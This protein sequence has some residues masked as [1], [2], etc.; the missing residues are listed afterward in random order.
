MQA[1]EST[2]VSVTVVADDGTERELKNEGIWGQS[3]TISEMVKDTDPDDKI[4]LHAVTRDAL[5][6][7]VE[8]MENMASLETDGASETDKRAWLDEY[9]K[10]LEPKDQ[11]RVLFETITAASFMNVKGLLDELC[12]FVANSVMQLT[13]LE[14]LEHFGI[15]KDAMKWADE[16]GI[17]NTEL[18]VDPD[19]LIAKDRTERL[20]QDADKDAE[21]GS[22]FNLLT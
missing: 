14:V 20:A 22:Y 8:Y 1:A 19:G 5:D 12:Q 18:W 11:Q 9:N 10:S 17:L 7:V 21:E 16:K 3:E 2:E 4:P 15:D 13:P 6:K